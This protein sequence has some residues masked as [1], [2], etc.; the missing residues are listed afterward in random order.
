MN[1][2]FASD[3]QRF[4]REDI[5]KHRHWTQDMVIEEIRQEAAAGCDLSY[6]CSLKRSRVLLRAAERVFGRWSAA[7]EAAG[8]DYAAQRKMRVWTKERVIAKIQAWHAQGADLSFMHAA[9]VLDP[10]LVAAA[11]HAGRFA[12][13]N[14]AL[15]AAGLDPETICHA[16]RWTRERIRREM[17]DLQRQGIPLKQATLQQVNPRLLA[18]IY[19]HE[20]SLCKARLALRIDPV[21]DADR[22]S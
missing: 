12:S 16:R 11:L 10:P 21:A 19:R 22:P 8:I 13:W 15:R 9:E 17:T 1:R 4:F 20:R 6:V 18:A 5:M 7:V 3:A 14:D 2:I